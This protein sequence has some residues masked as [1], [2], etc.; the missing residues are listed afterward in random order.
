ML[1]V[2]TEGCP[3]WTRTVAPLLASKEVLTITRDEFQTYVVNADDDEQIFLI[4][5]RAFSAPQLADMLGIERYP[6]FVLFEGAGKL[7]ELI[8]HPD[9]TGELQAILEYAVDSESGRIPIEQT[10]AYDASDSDVNT[11]L[12]EDVRLSARKVLN[13]EDKLDER[14]LAVFFENPTCHECEHF[15]NHI[16]S[17]SDTRSLL[18]RFR[19]VRFSRPSTPLLIEPP[20]R[21]L[22][23]AE[24]IRQLGVTSTPAVVLFDSSG[25]RIRHTGYDTGLFEFQSLLDY[26]VSGAYQSDPSFPHFLR[27]RVEHLRSHGYDIDTLVY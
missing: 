5:G 11:L 3:G 1:I 7:L 10:G 9:S 19:I 21:Q 24:W 4:E 14:P 26:V 8:E 25:K 15:R 27:H 16:L 2:H 23:V 18:A 17:D 22:T 13:L 12:G 20:E 6:T